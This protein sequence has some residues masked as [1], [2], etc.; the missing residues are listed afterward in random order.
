MGG[1][2]NY[3]LVPNVTHVH[4]PKHTWKLFVWKETHDKQFF[5]RTIQLKQTTLTLKLVH[6]RNMISKQT[7][8]QI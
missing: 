2:R 3:S 7:T 8:Q 5:L 1:V 6:D 4:W